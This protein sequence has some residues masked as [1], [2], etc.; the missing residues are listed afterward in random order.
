MAANMRNVLG[1]DDSEDE[2][3]AAGRAGAEA[4][5]PFGLL[6]AVAFVVN[7]V[8]SIWDARAEEPCLQ[9]ATCSHIH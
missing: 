3:M 9:L 5:V 4:I 2:M 7:L 8:C 1:E 6:A